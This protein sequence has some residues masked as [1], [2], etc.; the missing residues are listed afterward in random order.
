MSSELSVNISSLRCLE[1]LYIDNNNIT[2]TLPPEICELSALKYINLSNNLMEGRIPDDIGDLLGLKVCI[3]SKNYFCGPMPRSVSKLKN[4]REFQL[5]TALPAGSMTQ[6]DGF[7]KC[8]F[9]R[10]N[11]WS[12]RVGIDNV[13]WDP[14]GMDD[15]GNIFN[16]DS[17]PSDNTLIEASEQLSDTEEG[18]EESEDE[19]NLRL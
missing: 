17:I 7:K 3:L 19:G 6:Y 8:N 1:L 2:G 13:C 11:C 16:P 5:F 10:V 9:E 14:P 18:K 4:L 12:S 15:I